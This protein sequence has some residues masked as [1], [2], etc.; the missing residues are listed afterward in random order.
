[1]MNGMNKELHDFIPHITIP[2]IDDLHIKGC[3]IEVKDEAK[4]WR[5]C[6]KFVAQHNLDCDAIL[7]KLEEVHLTLSREKPI[8]GAKEVLIVGHMCEPYGRRPS[9]AKVEAIQ[10]MKETCTSV[11]EVRRFLGACVFYMI[12]LPHYAHVADVLYQLLRKGQRFV[13]K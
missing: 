9:P 11:T 8:F 12:W 7:S 2:F 13:R 5:G 10:K 4:D 6:R 3:E 1:M